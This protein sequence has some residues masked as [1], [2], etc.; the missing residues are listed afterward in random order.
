MAFLK[1]ERRFDIDTL[2]QADVDT[3]RE[4]LGDPKKWLGFQP[5]IVQFHE[6]AGRPGFYR[7]RD[8]LAFLG[9]SF[10]AE[11]RARIEPHSDGVDSEAWSVP[12]IHLT[13]RLRWTAEGASTRLT[14]QTTIEA[15][16][17]VMS[18]VERTARES[19]RAMYERLRA[20][21]EARIRPAP[22]GSRHSAA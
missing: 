18:Y 4:A 6:E 19:H 22:E 5:L 3:I 2:I 14:E 8:R 11:Y 20:A 17:P 16:A 10:E 7:V 9:L 13:V 12:F 15:P 1:S 21:I